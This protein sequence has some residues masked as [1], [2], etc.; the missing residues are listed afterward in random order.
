MVTATVQT[1]LDLSK[2]FYSRVGD[3]YRVYIPKE[4]REAVRVMPGDTLWLI[5]G[6]IIARNERVILT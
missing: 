3:D 1:V 4:F 2:S 5:V 6:T